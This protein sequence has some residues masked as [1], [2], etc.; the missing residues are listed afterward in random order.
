[1][2][3]IIASRYQKN[4]ANK[5]L[6]MVTE[7]G[8]FRGVRVDYSTYMGDDK[9]KPPDK[10]PDYDTNARARANYDGSLKQYQSRVAS[11]FSSM[12]YSAADFR[13]DGSDVFID[14]NPVEKNLRWPWQKGTSVRTM[15]RLISHTKQSNL[16]K[17]G[18]WIGMRQVA[19]SLGI[20]NAVFHPFRAIDEKITGAFWD[21]I[22]KRKN[23]SAVA[24]EDKKKQT[25]D[26]DGNTTTEYDPDAKRNSDEINDINKKAAEADTSNKKSGRSKLGGALG[27][28]GGI[29]GLI[30]TAVCTIQQLE[31]QATELSR[32]VVEKA[33]TAYMLGKG[34]ASQIET[35]KD[36][37][38]LLG[39]LDD[40]SDIMLY[41]HD[42]EDYTLNEDGT[43]NESIPPT[44]HDVAAEDSALFQKLEYGRE[45][46]SETVPIGLS[47]ISDPT[48]LPPELEG[49]TTSIGGFGGNICTGIGGTIVQILGFAAGII[50]GPI[51]FLAGIAVDKL[52]TNNVIEWL[53][54][55]AMNES[56]QDMDTMNAA[57]NLTTIGYGARLSSGEQ[58]ILNG[59]A[60]V[61]ASE[62]NKLGLIQEQYLADYYNSKPL[63]EKLFDPTNYNSLVARLGR[64]AKLD[65]YDK[66]LP[67]TISN[68]AKLVATVPN[69]AL[70]ELSSSP[71]VK[72]ANANSW[73]F[74]FDFTAF[75]DE[76]M[77]KLMYE[78]DYDMET[79]EARAFELLDQDFDKY[80]NFAKTCMGKV[81]KKTGN[82]YEVELGDPPAYYLVN[83]D[84]NKNCGYESDKAANDFLTIRTWAGI[85]TQWTNEVVCAMDEDGED[86]D[87]ALRAEIQRACRFLDMGNDASTEN[88]EGL[89]IG[90]P[91]N[92]DDLGGGKW[93]ARSYTDYS[94]IPCP[95]GTALATD[96]GTN[97]VY[98][99]PASHTRFRACII[100]G[101]DANN[102]DPV[103]SLV[104]GNV[105]AMFERAKM[106]G[107]TLNITDGARTYELQQQRWNENGCGSEKDANGRYT[108]GA[109]AR[110]NPDTARPGESNHED[111]TAIDLGCNGGAMRKWDACFT[112]LSDNA[113]DY[114]FFNYPNE[115]WHWSPSGN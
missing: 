87:D 27:K 66:S 3:D 13:I 24:T 102:D 20:V 109:K 89:A 5:G 80:N 38:N 36:S 108:N 70:R 110:C 30:I 97:G 32:G 85:D 50:T 93:K 69:L 59:G 43:I 78:D 25:T 83:S 74:G 94:D 106:D 100:P 92:V 103:G 68:F 65:P 15:D 34:F 54:S 112:W 86:V 44:Y 22:L 96:F 107:V 6:H 90:T 11:T 2:G 75:S 33:V 79:N 98:E 84:Y 115:A 114:H 51:S 45:G 8:T 111:G 62:A 12:G 113:A 67:A 101:M 52:L 73:D 48:K 81:I 10:P 77:T 91:D 31:S 35:G 41:T 42:V 28:A 60:T 40:M 53:I 82:S 61:S 55:K 72:A 17:I 23:K 63:N 14:M 88:G 99:N 56:L 71:A 76:E 26:K 19:K 105:M 64:E 4:L 7:G 9:L 21:K 57:E 18:H 46:D 29:V 16:S 37:D 104:A 58:T 47:S 49:L 95:A 39:K 1:M